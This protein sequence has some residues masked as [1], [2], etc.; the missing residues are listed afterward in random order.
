MKRFHEMSAH[1]PSDVES[2][3]IL[4]FYIQGAS[5]AP[6]NP[7]AALL[8]GYEALVG[9]INKWSGLELWS[10]KQARFRSLPH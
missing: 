10:G 5:A 7:L 1:C 8:L 9:F 2:S 6:L 3:N 4:T